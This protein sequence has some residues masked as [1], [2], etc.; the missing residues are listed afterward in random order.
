MKK[1]FIGSIAWIVATLFVVYAFFLNTA[2]AVFADTIKTALKAS[3]VEAA[4]AVGAFVLGFAC[5]QIPGGYLL[6]RFN[7]RY[8]VSSG[9]FLL[10]LGN[11]TLSFSNSLPLFALSNFIQGIGASFA[12][13]AVGKIISQWFAPNLFPILFGLTQTISCLLTAIIHYQLV[14]ALETITWQSIYQ[15]FSLFGFA[16]LIVTFFFV[17][18]PSNAKEEKPLSLKE[19]LSIVFR[20]NQVW[21]AAIGAATSFGALMA[22]ASFWYVNVEKFYSVEKTQAL[23]ISGMIFAGIGIGT[24][25]L[26]WLSNRFKSRKALIH[27]SL[28][29]GNMFLLAGLYSPHLNIET[30]IPIKT[31]SFFTGFFLSGSMLFYTTASELSSNNTRAVALSVVN[32]AVFLFNSLL[33]FLPYFSITEASTTFFTYLW[34]LPFCMM[35]SLLLAY[36]VK[37]TYTKCT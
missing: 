22:Y 28:A 33:L 25:F 1:N 37:E 15:Q 24:P 20:N 11:L 31:I 36:F 3:D 26:G 14:I 23:I 16:L 2:G 8:I 5:M 10:A 19:S 27:I 12:F 18:K 7:I 6:D 32:T 4:L 29:L 35:I 17:K 21:L 30:L 9:V 34:I 13:I